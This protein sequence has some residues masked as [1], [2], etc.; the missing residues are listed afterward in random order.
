MG[1]VQART[2]YEPL[3]P[4]AAARIGAT[5]ELVA[6]FIGSLDWRRSLAVQREVLLAFF[7]LHLRDRPAPLLDGPTPGYP[8]LVFRKERGAGSR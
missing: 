3:L 7:D 4:Q 6:A 1:T 5:P 2:D 8:E